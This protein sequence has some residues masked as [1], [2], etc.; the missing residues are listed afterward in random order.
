GTSTNMIPF[1]PNDQGNRAMMAAKMQE[2]AISLKEREAPL[3]QSAIAKG[4]TY[5]KVLGESQAIIAP[6]DA[7][8]VSLK[9]LRLKLKSG[10]VIDFSTY[11]NFPLSGGSFL[12]H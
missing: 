5:E 7:T 1:L 12:H 2:Q 4:Q 3:V 9:P 8:V 6:D 11:D 10:K